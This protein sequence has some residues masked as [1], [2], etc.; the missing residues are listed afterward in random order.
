M[1]YAEALDQALCFGWID[2]IRRK[3]DEE[4]YTNR[5]TPRRKNSNWSQINK[6]HVRRL[7]QAGLMTPSGLGAYALKNK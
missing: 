3:V 2:G 6:G 5:F 1:T 7:I 4:K